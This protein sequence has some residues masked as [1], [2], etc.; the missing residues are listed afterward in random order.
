[1]SSK[2]VPPREF[3]PIRGFVPK[4]EQELVLFKEGV[5]CASNPVKRFNSWKGTG[6]G[7][8]TIE[9]HLKAVQSGLG[10]ATVGNKKKISQIET[11]IV[12]FFKL[13]SEF[14]RISKTIRQRPDADDKE[15]FHKS[16]VSIYMCTVKRFSSLCI[17]WLATRKQFFA[18]VPISSIEERISERVKDQESF[19]DSIK[20]EN[21]HK[22]VLRKLSTKVLLD[23]MK[24]D[25]ELMLRNRVLIDNKI[26]S[27]LMGC[28][29]LEEQKRQ[30]LNIQNELLVQKQTLTAKKQEFFDELMDVFKN[31]RIYMEDT[32]YNLA[33]Y[34]IHQ[35][36]CRIDELFACNLCF[37]QIQF[38]PIA[39]KDTFNKTSV[40]NGKYE[41]Q[42]FIRNRNLVYCPICSYSFCFRCYYKLMFTLSVNAVPG[43]E[44]SG[45]AFHCPQCREIVVKKADIPTST[46]EYMKKSKITVRVGAESYLDS[47]L[48]AKIG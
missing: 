9:G 20:L 1:M 4:S 22:N 23:K 10:A 36:I 37:E 32:Q 44:S 42:C 45:I 8:G 3:V 19:Y 34:M 29:N 41:G 7:L 6:K 35:D 12:A 39:N 24:S 30:T 25:N 5:L 46:K 47:F 48:P 40:H 43:L 21:S 11:S 27:I 13:A 33:V 31:F 28:A 15:V 14:V 18:S 26:N 16:M 17:D 38:L 2:K